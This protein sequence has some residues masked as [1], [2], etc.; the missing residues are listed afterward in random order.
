MVVPTPRQG[1][2]A[3]RWGTNSS[4]FRLKELLMPH[5][6]TPEFFAGSWI[7]DAGP[8]QMKTLATYPSTAHDV[9]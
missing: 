1:F 4:M 6:N 2:E 5:E 7:V 8:N 3:E 9:Q